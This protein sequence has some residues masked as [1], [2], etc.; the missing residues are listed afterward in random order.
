M[1]EELSDLCG[2]FRHINHSLESSLPGWRLA[3]KL[4]RE[5]GQVTKSNNQEQQWQA[6]PQTA[7]LPRRS[8]ATQ[9]LRQWLI[10]P[11]DDALL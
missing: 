9:L 10:P 3:V 8:S 1:I 5:Q 11:T 4:P 6:E 7:T 2:K